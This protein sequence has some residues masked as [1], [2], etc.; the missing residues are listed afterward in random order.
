[1]EI[2]M[3]MMPQTARDLMPIKRKV[4]RKVRFHFLI[5]GNITS[6]GLAPSRRAISP[7]SKKHDSCLQISSAGA[8][9]K[10]KVQ[11]FGVIGVMPKNLKPSRIL[12]D[13]FNNDLELSLEYRA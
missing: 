13:S 8:T 2:K 1:M 7:S 3:S 4:P 10:D 9:E 6:Y 5:D 12:T 11:Y